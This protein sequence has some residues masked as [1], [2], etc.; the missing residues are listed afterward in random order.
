MLRWIAARRVF[1]R[2]PAIARRCRSPPAESFPHDR[3]KWT[4]F[5]AE[6][7]V[8]GGLGRPGTLDDKVDGGAA[9]AVLQKDLDGGIQDLGPSNLAAR[10]GPPHCRCRCRWHGPLVFSK[11]SRT[12]AYHWR[13]RCHVAPSPR[14]AVV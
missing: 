5:A 1:G 3:G 11:T 12:L 9:V 8:N 10:S 13:S 4:M 6:E 2:M 7:R 14:R